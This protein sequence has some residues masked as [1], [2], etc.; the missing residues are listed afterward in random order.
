MSSKLT[1]KQQLF[2]SAYCSNGFNGTQA[3]LAAGYAEKSA[4]F[5]GHE[6]LTKP[7]IIEEIDKYKASISEKHMITVDSLI[8]ELEEAR[9]VALS[10][11]TPQ[12]SAAISATMGK[13][14]LCGLDKKI[15]DHQSSDGSMTPKF[16]NLY[17]TKPGGES[18][19]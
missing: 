3:A 13:A 16:S 1:T 2:V 12:S 9:Q 14:K 11:E 7:Y 18:K 6:N 19:S 4:R 5:V 17:G 15:I 10:A 8:E